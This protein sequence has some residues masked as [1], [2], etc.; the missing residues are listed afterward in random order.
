MLRSLPLLPVREKIKVLLLK[1]AAATLMPNW[2][3]V[4][5]ARLCQMRTLL[6]EEEVVVVVAM[7]VVITVVVVTVEEGEEV[8][9]TTRGRQA[10]VQEEMPSSCT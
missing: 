5:V 10:M 8:P 7:A 9:P 1:E 4:V 6:G 3:G 2:V